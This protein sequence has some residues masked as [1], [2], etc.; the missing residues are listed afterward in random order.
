[1]YGVLLG[2]MS[3]ASQIRISEMPSG[4]RAIEKCDPLGVLSCVISTHMNNKRYVE[5][6]NMT[7]VIKRL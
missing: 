4:K 2:Q 5:T 3:E 6:F 1:M 7:I